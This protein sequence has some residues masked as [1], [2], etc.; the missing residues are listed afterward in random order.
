MLFRSTIASESA[1]L[2]AIARDGTP[3]DLVGKVT[4]QCYKSRLSQTVPTVCIDFYGDDR[5]ISKAIC[6]HPYLFEI[7]EEGCILNEDGTKGPLFDPEKPLSA[8]LAE[9][10][11]SYPCA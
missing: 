6:E 9:V 8:T 10:M 2:F 1:F 11:P 5:K 7:D 4:E 3:R